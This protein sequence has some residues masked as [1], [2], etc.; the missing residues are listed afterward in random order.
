[1]NAWVEYANERAAALWLMGRA[2]AAFSQQGLRAAMNGWVEAAAEHSRRRGL[3]SGLV[4]GGARD[5]AGAQ[6]LARDDERASVDAACRRVHA[7]AWAAG[8]FQ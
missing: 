5:S 6:Q 4:A 7:P 1:M 3:L 8:G 2:A